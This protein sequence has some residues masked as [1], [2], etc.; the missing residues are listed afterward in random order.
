LHPFQS[1]ARAAGSAKSNVTDGQNLEWM[2]AASEKFPENLKPATENA[3][4]ELIPR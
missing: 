3:G 4:P 1:P 2:K